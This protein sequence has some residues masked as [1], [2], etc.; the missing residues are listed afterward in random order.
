MKKFLNRNDILLIL[1]DKESFI[2]LNNYGI[3]D[4]HYMYITLVFV[5]QDLMYKPEKLRMITSNSLY[6]I[7]F[8]NTG[9]KCNLHAIFH[10]WKIPKEIFTQI[11]KNAYKN[12]YKYIVFSNDPKIPDNSRI[13]TGIFP[14]KA[15]YV[16]AY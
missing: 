12:P 10:N 14:N 7:V 15:M 5:C 2:H 16:Y 8:H 3:K 1:D 6:Q 13:R 4:C 9:D 11:I